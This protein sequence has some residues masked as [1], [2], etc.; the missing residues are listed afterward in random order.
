MKLYESWPRGQLEIIMVVRQKNDGDAAD[1]VKARGIKFP[2][3]A[4]ANGEITRLYDANAFPA[5]YFFNAYGDIKIKRATAVDLCY[6]EMDSL[7][8]LY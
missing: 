3:I 2:V 8:R 7:L 1:W 6:E 4:D 5:F